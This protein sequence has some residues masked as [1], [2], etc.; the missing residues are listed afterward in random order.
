MSVTLNTNLGPLKLELFCDQV[1]KTCKNFLALCASGYY[2]GTKF[3]RSIPDFIVQGGDP[4]GTGKGGNSIY[5]KYFD[6]EI[7]ETLKHS[8][9]GI[10]SMANRGPNTN[11]SQF[12][13]IYDKQK[14]L[15]N[16]NTV[17]GRI[18][19]GMDTLDSMEKMKVDDKDRPIRPITIQSV[20]IHANPFAEKEF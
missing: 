19:H 12:F 18:I 7:V 11:G 8:S 20:K 14:H 10:V 6:D 9:R 17:F 16:V 15:D 4:T 5:G 1:P 13:F 2:N 3:H